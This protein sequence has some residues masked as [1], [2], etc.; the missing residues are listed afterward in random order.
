MTHLS[1]ITLLFLA[2]F[3]LN[4]C[5]YNS[6]R[7]KEEGVFKAWGDVESTL[8]RRGDL[9]PNLVETVKGYATHE[10]ETLE[11]VIS[12]RAKASSIQLSS[13]DL[14]NPAAMQQLQAAQGGLTSALSKLMLIVERYPD[15]HIGNRAESMDTCR[16]R[17]KHDNRGEYLGKYHLR[18]D[19]GYQKQKQV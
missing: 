3:L 9:I 15:L 11:A 16:P 4:G 10:A 6:L 18:A 17:Y 8:Q 13:D 1:K 12:A 5:S 19:S 2:F 7:T 14:S